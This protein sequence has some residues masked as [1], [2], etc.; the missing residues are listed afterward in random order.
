MNTDVGYAIATGC[1]VLFSLL[2]AFDGIYFH[3]LK[4]KLHEHPPAKLEHQIHTFRGWLFIPIALI[5][6]VWNSSGIVLWLGL[7]LLCIDF[8]AETVDIMVEKEAR[9][10]LGGIS[11]AE[12]VIHVM[13]TGF[14]MAAIAI[15]LAFKPTFAYSIIETR[16]LSPL[17]SHLSNIGTLFVGGLI[18]ALG[19][20]Y[21]QSLMVRWKTNYPSNRCCMRPVCTV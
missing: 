1:L 7:A 11:S 19:T 8:I 9:K 2:G 6:F 13:A 4:Y 5:F 10:E 12:T 16:P 15:V 17:P 14:R 18:L 3:M 21:I 20:Q